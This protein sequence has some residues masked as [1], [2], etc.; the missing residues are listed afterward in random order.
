MTITRREFLGLSSASL[1]FGFLPRGFHGVNLTEIRRG[2][3]IFTAR[4]G[5]I[6]WLANGGGMVA[7]DSQYP[8]T[9][10]SFLEALRARG[11]VPL[12]ALINTHHHGDHTAGN[13]VLR[14]SVRRIVAH[15][16]VPELQRVA[17]AGT[18]A[19]ATQAY[20]DTVFSGE[21]SI[22]VGDETV[23]AKH[24]G[25]GHTAGDATVFFER[26][27]VVHMGDLVFSRAYPFVDR[28]GGASIRGW[29]DVLER[30]TAEHGEGTIYVFGH[31]NPA[32]SITGTRA[33]V[34]LERDFLS[35]VLETAERAIAAGRSREEV[36]AMERLPGFPDHAPLAASLTLAMPLGAAYDEL[37]GGGA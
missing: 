32:A 19:E 5:T 25:A 2:V 15:E 33:D 18:A 24:Y 3:G 7:V 36:V 31:A 1:L 16:R 17:A 10:Q 11:P 13:G 26:A 29:V 20:P 22:Q 6:G 8:D 34:L 12:D 28:P 27:D 30:V 4:G 23:R 35:A 9:A 21:W 37:R 14:E